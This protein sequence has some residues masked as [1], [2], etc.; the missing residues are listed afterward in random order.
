M[1]VSSRLPYN[2][3]HTFLDDKQKKRH[4]LAENNAFLSVGYLKA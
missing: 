3:Y 4:K 2:Q 1:T